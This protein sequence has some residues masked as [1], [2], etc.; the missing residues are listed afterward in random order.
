[1]VRRLHTSTSK[2]S[3]GFASRYRF[4]LARRAS[5]VCGTPPAR[6]SSNPGP[7]AGATTDCHVEVESERGAKLRLEL[8]RH[9]NGRTGKLDSW[10]SWALTGM[11]QITP[12]S[13]FH[14]AGSQ[15][16]G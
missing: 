10:I 9:C 4:K 14:E 12:H 15:L 8:K 3:V 1:M 2:A 7:T 11:L 5:K 13:R 6:L 16:P